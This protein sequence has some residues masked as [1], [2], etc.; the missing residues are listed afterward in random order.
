MKNTRTTMQW[1]LLIEK[2]FQIALLQSSTTAMIWW[3]DARFCSP[4]YYHIIPFTKEGL[5]HEW[6]DENKGGS[7]QWTSDKSKE[8]P[9][10][11]PLLS[12]SRIYNDFNLWS[13][14]AA[15]NSE[16]QQHL[17][18]ESRAGGRGAM[19]ARTDGSRY[20]FLHPKES[21]SEFG[22]HI[23]TWKTCIKSY[24]RIL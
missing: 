18:P 4:S 19:A 13:S 23:S 11:S 8:V 7:E 3:A 22:S 12:M 15:Q 16:G 10:F 17:E 6:G 9:D 1:A 21:S 14:S 2:T 5:M 24:F 20:P